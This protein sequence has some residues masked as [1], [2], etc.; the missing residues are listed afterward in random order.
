MLLQQQIQGLT[1]DVGNG[2]V[3]GSPTVAKM[4]MSQ[5]HKLKDLK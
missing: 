4:G 1:I 5:I 3:G 2:T